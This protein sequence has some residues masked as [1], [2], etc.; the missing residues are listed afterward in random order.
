[1]TIKE[2]KAHLIRRIRLNAGLNQT[3][4]AK[5]IN[6]IQSNVSRWENGDCIPTDLTMTKIQRTFRA[7][8]PDD[9]FDYINGVLPNQTSIF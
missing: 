8:Y 4:F 6:V 3:Q 9:A 5:R 7:Y 2:T 1:M